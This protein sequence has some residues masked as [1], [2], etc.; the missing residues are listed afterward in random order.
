MGAQRV[1]ETNTHLALRALVAVR[2]A[3]KALLDERLRGELEVLERREARGLERHHPDEVAAARTTRIDHVAHDSGDDGG[4]VDAVVGHIDHH[5][6]FTVLRGEC[7]A[8]ASGPDG[9]ARATCSMIAASHQKAAGDAAPFAFRQRDRLLPG[10]VGHSQRAMPDIPRRAAHRIKSC[11]D[12]EPPSRATASSTTGKS[13]SEYCD[14]RRGSQAR[15]RSSATRAS[16]ASVIK[17]TASA[18]ADFSRAVSHVQST[19][20][21]RARGPLSAASVGSASACETAWRANV[22]LGPT[23][24]VVF[25]FVFPTVLRA[26]ALGRHHE[27]EQQFRGSFF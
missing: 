19:A 9:R 20:G 23:S 15:A 16:L 2:R 14:T 27:V 12:A 17:S 7:T 21:T 10:G 13:R 6:P 8:R 22:S 26:P 5:Q 25:P 1:R 24:L 11:M 3:A 4:G 18:D